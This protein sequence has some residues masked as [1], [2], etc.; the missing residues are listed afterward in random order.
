MVSEDKMNHIRIAM[1]YANTVRSSLGPMGMNNMVI[2]EKDGF[3]IFSNDGAT[4]IKNL[5]VTHPVC[6]MIKTL[7][8]GQEKAIGDGTTSVTVL[9]AN[10]L[11]VSLDLLNKGMHPT[12]I[13]TGFDAAKNFAVDYTIRNAELGDKSRIIRTSFGSKIPSELADYLTTLISN[14]NLRKLSCTPIANK[15]PMSS[16]IIKGFV[17]PGFTINDRMPSQID[18]K[19]AVLDIRSTPDSAKVNLSS[20]EEL[21]KYNENMKNK[22][23]EIAIKLKK[24]GV[25]CVFYTDTNVEIENFI[26]ENEL[27]GIVVYKREYLDKI[28]AAANAKIISDIDYDLESFLGVGKV[29]YEK[30]DQMI[31]LENQDSKVETLLLCGPTKHVLD[32]MQRAVD[33]VVNVA[34]FGDKVLVGGGAFEIEL[35]NAIRE[36]SKKIIGKEKIAIEKYAEAIEAFPRILAENC[37]F[38]ALDILSILKTAHEDG[39]KHY[40]VDPMLRISDAKERGIYEPMASK[41]HLINAAT[42][43]ANLIIKLDGIYAGDKIEKQ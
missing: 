21:N 15:D 27:M 29:T 39:K 17:F 14:L 22:K 42:D 37:G 5:R 26:T 1:D 11:E 23:K 6:H 24:A 12:T 2:N 18:G 33:D 19:I 43:V 20:T 35:A 40:G 9:C 3:P 36:Y 31:Y 25:K 34:K 38:D 8:E 16:K 41:V 7:A 4:I 13:I 10:L 30:E 32:E 28:T